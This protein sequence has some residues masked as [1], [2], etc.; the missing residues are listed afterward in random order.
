MEGNDIL[1]SRLDGSK[2][3]VQNI[4]FYY[5]TTLIDCGVED[6]KQKVASEIGEM[7]ELSAEQAMY[8]KSNVSSDNK[9]VEGLSSSIGLLEEMEKSGQIDKESIRIVISLLSAIKKSCESY[10]KN[11]GGKDE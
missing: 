8:V 2:S 10:Q 11:N 6:P 3:A 4:L 5:I 1:R 7:I 9:I